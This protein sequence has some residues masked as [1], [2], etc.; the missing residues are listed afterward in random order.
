ML[1]LLNWN[2]SLIHSLLFNSLFENHKIGTDFPALAQ[3]FRPLYNAKSTVTG[4]TM[5]SI[6]SFIFHCD[7]GHPF[8]AAKLE[9]GTNAKS[10]PGGHCYAVNLS[11]CPLSPPL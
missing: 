3:C 2:Y 7:A 1:L 6:M 5:D 10:R 4:M 9:A 11:Y 8:S